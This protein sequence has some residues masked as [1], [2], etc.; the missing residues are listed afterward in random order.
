MK[1]AKVT[2]IEFMAKRGETDEGEEAL[3]GDRLFGCGER[4]NEII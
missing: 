4:Q 2:L 1:C 3:P